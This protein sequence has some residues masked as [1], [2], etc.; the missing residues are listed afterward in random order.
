[1]MAY[2][3]TFFGL[4]LLMILNWIAPNITSGGLLETITKYLAT[5]PH[6]ENFLK[7]MITVADLAY[8]LCF[9]SLF[10][11]FT[12]VVLDSQRWR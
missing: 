7:G 9:A 1:M 10:L 6:L 11:F 2:L 8:F 4:F 12:N 5:N 3:F